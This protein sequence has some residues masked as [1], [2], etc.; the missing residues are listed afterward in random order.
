MCSLG[1]RNIERSHRLGRDTRRRDLVQNAEGWGQKTITSSGLQAPPRPTTTSATSRAGPPAT[2][3]VFSLDGVKK[4]I[5]RLSGDQNGLDA[6]SVPARGFASSESNART[7]TIN[8]PFKKTVKASLRPS[9]DTA[10]DSKEAFSGGKMERRSTAVLFGA[11]DNRRS[12][13]SGTYLPLGKEIETESA[14]PSL[15]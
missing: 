6:N 11:A 7:Q 14:S 10:K 5:D 15:S 12:E 8:F 1:V 3:T 4:P 13:N 2:S 9:G